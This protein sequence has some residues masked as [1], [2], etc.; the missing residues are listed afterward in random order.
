M[1]IIYKPDYPVT[2]ILLKNS[3]VQMMF[4]KLFRPAKNIHYQRERLILPDGDFLDLDWAKQ[5]SQTLAI[6]CDGLE[7]NSA[8]L[9]VK[10]TVETLNENSIDA[11][12]INYRGCSGENNKKYFLQYGETADYSY[13]IDHVLASQ[14]Y[15]KIV[16]VG[17]SV[18]GNLILK[19]LCDKSSDL[20]K[21]IKAAFTI[22]PTVDLLSSCEELHTLKDWLVLKGFLF[23]LF[24]RVWKM[25]DSFERKVYLWDFFRIKTF[26]NF[27]DR[28][29]F[30]QSQLPLDQY[31]KSNSA[32]ELLEK[33]TIPSYILLS[34]D[35]PMVDA[36]FYPYIQAEN[37]PN[38]TLHITKYGG[39]VGFINFNQ[40][41]FWSESVMNEF[42]KSVIS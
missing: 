38:I 2:N 35:D 4:A 19:Y 15:E 41:S 42:F 8:R 32:F 27:Y 34:Q 18:G 17:C 13:I 6:V 28:Y 3:F 30:R 29:V 23:L 22:S 31:L 37:N 21:R 16:L 10:S 7:G 1:P 39:H 36:E 24:Q 40:K 14:N 26:K 11:L 20:N 25:R 33:I 9:Y 12:A 5:G